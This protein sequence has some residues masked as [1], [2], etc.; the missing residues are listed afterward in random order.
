MSYAVYGARATRTFRVL[1]LLEELG[2]DYTHHAVKPHDPVLTALA[3]LGKVPV[4]V[5][6]DAVIGDSSAILTHLADK[7]GAFTAPAG[8]VARARQDAWTFRILDEVEGPLWMA[9]KHSFIL[10]EQERVAAVKP[11]C[12]AEYA[13]AITRIFDEAEGPYLTGDALTV[14]DIVLGHC[15]GWAKNAGFPEPTAAFAAYLERVRARPAF[16]AAAAL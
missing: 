9:A 5:D 7:H 10:P 4:L 14:P 2:A 11:S 3:P 15:G 1:W 12:K 16:K 13:R 6:G 8:S